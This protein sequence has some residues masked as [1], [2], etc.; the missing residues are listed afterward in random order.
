M[1]KLEA[2]LLICYDDAETAEA[3][4]SAVS[5]DNFKAPSGLFVETKRLGC[6]VSTIIKC[7]DGLPAFLATIDDLLFCINV[8][9]KTVKTLR[10]SQ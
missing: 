7:D 1:K 5:P 9:E 10:C 6:E 4:A 8:A 3:V 2:E